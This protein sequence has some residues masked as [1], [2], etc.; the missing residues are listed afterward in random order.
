MTVLRGVTPGETLES[1]GA[2]YKGNSNADTCPALVGLNGGFSGYV[3]PARD[4]GCLSGETGLGQG[5]PET[6]QRNSIHRT[7]AGSL[8]L[9]QLFSF[10]PFR[11][12]CMKA[13]S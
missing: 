7:K 13:Q 12:A 8:R 3:S 9:C 1:A 4:T 2:I 10:E 11:N 5:G 6:L